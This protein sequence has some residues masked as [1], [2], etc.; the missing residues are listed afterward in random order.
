MALS[1]SVQKASY[2]FANLNQGYL[3]CAKCLLLEGKLEKA[4]ELY[5][6]AL[7]TLP[8]NHPRREVSATVQWILDLVARALLT[9]VARRTTT[10]QASR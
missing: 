2:P 10:Q 4:L 1:P 9:C 8:S 5:A 7:K 3:R 6:Y